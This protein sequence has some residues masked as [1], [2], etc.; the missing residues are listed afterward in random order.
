MLNVAALLLSGGLAPSLIEKSSGI[1]NKVIF[2]PRLFCKNKCP[3]H[4]SVVLC[5]HPLAGSQNR[6]HG[7]LLRAMGRHSW[8]TSSFGNN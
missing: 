1:L 5:E 8:V 4:A 2:P 7:V 6:Q 3:E